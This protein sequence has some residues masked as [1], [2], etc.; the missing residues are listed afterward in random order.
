[1]E[2]C[3]G[4]QS[5]WKFNTSLSP[6]LFGVNAEGNQR[7]H[8]SAQSTVSISFSTTTVPQLN[9]AIKVILWVPGFLNSTTGFSWLFSGTPAVLKFHLAETS[10]ESAFN[11]KWI[12]S[13]IHLAVYS[14]SAS[15]LHTTLEIV[16]VAVLVQALLSVI[17]IW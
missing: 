14:K 4:E 2:Y 1:M 16:I 8:E 5:L 9:S 17:I 7:W 10:T 15:H 12:G 6:S 11:S 13:C 3:S